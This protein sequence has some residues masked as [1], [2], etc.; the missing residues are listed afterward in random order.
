MSTVTIEGRIVRAMKRRTYSE[1]GVAEMTPHDSKVPISIVGNIGT[2]EAGLE[3]VVHGEWHEHP[4]YGKQFRVDDLMIGV[5]RSSMA[6]ERW[7]ISVGKLSPRDATK[8]RQALGKEVFDAVCTRPDVTAEVHGVQ[9]S[10]IHALRKIMLNTTMEHEFYVSGFG[11]G[12][13]STEI[14]KLWK[15]LSP[16][17][18]T[19]LSAAGGEGQVS[20][21]EAFY[22]KI[23]T[24][25]WSLCLDYGLSFA[26]VAVLA[27]D[28]GVTGRTWKIAGAALLES[29]RLAIQQGSC[30]LE[31][32]EAISGADA[33]LH[34]SSAHRHGYSREELAEAA[35]KLPRVHADD[36][37]L[38][39]VN[40]DKA[41]RGIAKTILRLV[42]QQKVIDAANRRAAKGR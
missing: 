1:W 24:D 9:P 20:A 16:E 27:E 30:G 38:V 7:L 32:D 2:V 36:G 39:P 25:P 14:R 3:V 11:V 35:G 21:I 37:I 29:L 33:V 10:V 17:E 42:K 18:R 26:R 8:L 22:H 19:A 34:D 31:L 28:W 5:P 40:L 4:S 12:L 13:S 23:V 15:A 6:I 41:E